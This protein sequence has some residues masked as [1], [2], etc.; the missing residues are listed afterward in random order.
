LCCIIY[1]TVLGFVKQS[2]T[3]G[4]GGV[5]VAYPRLGVVEVGY[6]GLVAVAYPGLGVVYP[7]L[8]VVVVAYPGP[9]VVVV[10]GVF[11][12]NW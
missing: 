11:L 3:P 2:F 4:R 9:G 5:V 6:P 7:G 10:C 1:I 8:G 12:E